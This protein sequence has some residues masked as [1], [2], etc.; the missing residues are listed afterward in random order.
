MHACADRGLAAVLENAARGHFPAT[1][2]AVE[3]LPAPPGPAMAVLALTAHY[4]ISTS[5]P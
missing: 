2:G 4:Y 3:L 1:D 5:A